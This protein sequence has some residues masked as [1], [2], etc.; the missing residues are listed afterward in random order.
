[1]FASQA[2]DLSC[3]MEV[4]QGKMAISVVSF[5]LL[6]SRSVAAIAVEVTH[7][8]ILIY[9]EGYIEIIFHSVVYIES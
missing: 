3:A 5:V 2:A 1:V 8:C 9:I 6:R 7:T 4:C